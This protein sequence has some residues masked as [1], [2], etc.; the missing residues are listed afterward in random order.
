M[1]RDATP[2]S[3]LTDLYNL[4]SEKLSYVYLGN[5]HL[6]SG[7]D[8]YCPEC[9]SLLISRN[10]YSTRIRGMDPDASCRKCNTPIKNIV[11]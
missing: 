6:S 7:Q 11:I 10:G 3:T 4:A 9:G 2:V 1:T 8:T 5:V